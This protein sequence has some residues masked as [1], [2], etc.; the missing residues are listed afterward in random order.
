[1]GA[2]TVG[3][4]RS[5]ACHGLALVGEARFQHATEA[6]L[7][8]RREGALARPHPPPTLLRLSPT[9]PPLL[10][11]PLLLLLLLV[12]VVAVAAAGWRFDR[13]CRGAAANDATAADATP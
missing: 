11:P 6:R 2:A 1:M 8:R 9:P 4:P 10:L 7:P 13:C 3:R 5:D 12:V